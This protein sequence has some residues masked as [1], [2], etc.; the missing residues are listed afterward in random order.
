MMRA[1]AGTALLLLAGAA[2]AAD[3][4]I[5]IGGSIGQA[6]VEVEDDLA[7]FDG[8]DTGFKVIAGI[9]PLDFLGF[10]LNYVDLGAPEEGGVE[11]DATGIDA[12][13]VG[14]LPLPLVDLFAKVGVVSWDSSVSVDGVEVVDDSGEDLAYGVGAQARFG[15]IAVRAEYEIFDIDDT[16]DVNMLSLGL[17]WTFL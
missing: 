17:T 3:N 5:Y 2:M 1:L 11:V 16:D 6:N 9:R 10:E 15:S 14:F 13:A 12:F 8:D 4:G 7:D